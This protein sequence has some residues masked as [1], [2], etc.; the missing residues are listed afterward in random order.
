MKIEDKKK[1]KR[2]FK[3]DAKDLK[4]DKI[5]PINRV[6]RDLSFLYTFSESYLSPHPPFSALG[7]SLN[8]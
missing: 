5:C 3:G 2:I 7:D 1:K 8:M 6:N 4:P